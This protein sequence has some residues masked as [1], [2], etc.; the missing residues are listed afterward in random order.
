MTPPALRLQDVRYLHR[1]QK[2][3]FPW[4]K[5]ATKASGVEQVSL[6]VQAGTTLGL[7]GESGC[8]KSTLASL[9]MGDRVPQAGTIDLFGT[10]LG[11]RLGKGR[12][13]LARELQMVAQDPFGSM[14]PRQ[15]I[16]P[17]LVETLDVHDEGAS[18]A[19]RRDRALAMLNQVGL[20]EISYERLPHQ[21]SGGQRQRV[22]I[23]RALI[24]KPR[25][26]VCDEPVSA[27]DV[28]VQAQVLDLVD[29]IRRERGLTVLFISHD[30][31]VVR[32]VCDETVV[33]RRG[34]IVERG[35][36]AEL[37]AAPQ[38]EYTRLLI[39]SVP[40]PGWDAEAAGAEVE[41]AAIDGG[42]SDTHADDGDAQARAVETANIEAGGQA[43]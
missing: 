5:P 20:S 10:P 11:E 35:L 17:Q 41:A 7:I 24:L 28:S 43:R 39:D 25:V 31:A 4:V 33:M 19:E 34:E 2:S 16:G 38:H 30:L 36:T 12:K 1:Q 29:R 3:L 22:A 18:L 21:L 23:A 37:L 6:S 14:D 26:L 27:L 40:K 9:I 13:A 8:G 42:G 32:R 15:A